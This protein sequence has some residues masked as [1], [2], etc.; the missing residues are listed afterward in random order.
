MTDETKTTREIADEDATREK[1]DDE[2]DNV[3]WRRADISETPV[4]VP[5]KLE[6]SQESISINDAEKIIKSICFDLEDVVVG[7][8]VHGLSNEIQSRFKFAVERLVRDE[9]KEEG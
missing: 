7:I 6:V 5:K 4:S 8:D 9:K 2:Q 3:R 1:W